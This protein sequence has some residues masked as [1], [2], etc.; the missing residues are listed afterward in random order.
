M[1]RRWIAPRA[2]ES[3]MRASTTSMRGAASS[4]PGSNT[5]KKLVAKRPQSTSRRLVITEGTATPPT[6]QKTES[7]TVTPSDCAR[8]VSIEMRAAPAESLGGS[9]SNQLPCA[10]VSVVESVSRQVFRYSRRSAQRSGD[11]KS[12]RLNSSHSQISYAVFCLK[13]KPEYLC[14]LVPD[15]D[16]H[17]Q[18]PGCEPTLDRGGERL[19]SGDRH[20]LPTSE[21]AVHLV[22]PALP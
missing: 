14:Q 16:R 13:K 19:R 2:A 21:A 18:D 6:S 9:A 10:I 12:T 4:T 5:T 7:P 20:G 3:G 17:L 15:P 8:S 11:R 1:S 22:R